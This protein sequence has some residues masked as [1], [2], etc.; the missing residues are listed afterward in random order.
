MKLEDFE[1]FIV[2]QIR[3]REKR[4]DRLYSSLYSVTNHVKIKILH[5]QIDKLRDILKWI[6]RFEVN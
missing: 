4:I 5:S 6:Y 1:N 2:L 3:K